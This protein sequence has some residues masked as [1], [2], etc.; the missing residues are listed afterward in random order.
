MQIRRSLC[1]GFILHID[2]RTK[3]IDC[4]TKHIDCNFISDEDTAPT[5]RKDIFENDLKQFGK[6][7]ESFN[8]H[9]DDQLK[10]IDKI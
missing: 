2:C 1:S 10:T 4:R 5:E 8:I 7:L 9:L 6:D 3:H